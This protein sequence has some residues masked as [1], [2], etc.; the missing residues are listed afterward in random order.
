MAMELVVHET[1]ARVATEAATRIAGLISDADDGFTLGLAGGST[2]L[3]TYQAL[4]GRP[5]NW[6]KVDAWLSD[7]RWVP[8]DHERSNGRMAAE[9]LLDHVE[10]SFHRPRWSELLDSSDSAAHYEATVRSIHEGK[11]PDL[12]LLGIGEDGHTASLFPE[13]AAL[14]EESRWIVSN[15]VPRLGE[16][17]ITVTYPALWGARRLMILATGSG[18][19]DAVRASF[20]G[21]TPAGRLGDG[22]AEVEWHLDASAAS[23]VS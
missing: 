23:L 1:A 15:E 11:P 10:A 17:R 3:A 19:A 4:R 21:D 8:H 5:T 2:P 12:I 22:N 13:T 16:T 6:G 7:E 18:K 9:A 20:E 14:E